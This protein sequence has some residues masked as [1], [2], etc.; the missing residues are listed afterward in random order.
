MKNK[1]F[2]LIELLASI[3]ILGMVAIIA[4]P[5]ILNLLSDSQN[6]IDK[7]KEEYVISAAREYVNDN[8]IKNNITVQELISNGYISET[9]VPKESVIYNGCI[10]IEENQYT[11]QK[12]CSQS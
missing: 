1:G 7:S 3:T 8:G 11:F 10:T 6:K 9:I 4:F 12:N 2:T 5:A